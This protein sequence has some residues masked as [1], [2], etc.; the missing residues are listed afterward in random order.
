MLLDIQNFTLS[1]Y[2]HELDIRG[3]SRT[4]GKLGKKIQRL[5]VHK[6]VDPNAVPVPGLCQCWYSILKDCE[7][8]RVPGAIRN[9]IN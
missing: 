1:V 4:N 5:T 3:K 2:F 8:R 7:V 9:I 6:C